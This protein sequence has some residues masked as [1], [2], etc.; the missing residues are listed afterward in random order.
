MIS[1]YKVLGNFI[2][3]VKTRNVDLSITTLLGINIDKFFMP[4]VANINGTDLSSY[5]IVRHRQFACNRMHVGRDYRIPI[6]LSNNREPFIVSPA[7]DVF[8]IIDSTILDP[9]YLMMWFSRKEFDRN[10]WFYTD[11][12]VRGGLPWDSFCQLKLPIPPIEKQHEIV[13]EYNI[14]QNRINLNNE[15]IARLEE[16]AQAIYKRWFVDFEFPDENGMPYKS[17]GGEMMESEWGLIPIGWSLDVISNLVE[18]KDGTHD[19][20]NPILT[21]YPLVTSTHLNLYDISLKETYNISETDFIE[22]NKRSKVEKFDILYS[23]IGT[24]GIVN[25]VLYDN[26]DFAVKNIGIF[27]TSKKKNISEYLLFFLKS[28]Y[29]K[30]FIQSSLLG[31]TQSYVTLNLLRSIHVLIPCIDLTKYEEIVEKIINAIYL[32]VNENAILES[33]KELLLSKIAI[34]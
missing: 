30:K 10:S 29:I 33:Q 14:I 12:D 5:K 18:V 20:P 11:A 22:I 15:L 8:E 16:T 9:E 4:S 28:D 27:K 19:S 21:G 24:I 13:A 17:S 26:I 32:R 6:S 7:Y 34:V 1:N 23:M 2:R 25:Y 31:S 3:E